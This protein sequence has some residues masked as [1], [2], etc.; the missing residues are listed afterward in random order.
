MSTRSCRHAASN[1]GRFGPRG[2]GDDR[3]RTLARRL[4]I[5]L[6]GTAAAALSMGQPTR[7]ASINDA[8]A[9]AAGGIANYWDSTN[10]YSNVVS[11]DLGSCSGTLI[12]SRTIIT[13]A[14]CF[15][16]NNGTYSG[17]AEQVSFNPNTNDNSGKPKSDV[18][19]AIVNQNF[20]PNANLSVANDIALLSLATPFP[21]VTAAKLLTANPGDAGFPQKD[22]VAVL[23]GYGDTGTG[24]KPDTPADGKRRVAYTQLGGYV[25]ERT[26]TVNGLQTNI[27]NACTDDIDKCILRQGTQPFFA[28]QFRDPAHPATFNYFSQG[29]DPPSLQ[30]G[31]RKGD[32]GGPLFWCPNGTPD[33]C[34][35]DQLV[36]I[37][38]LFG[39]Q[40]PVGG[41][42]EAYGDISGWT[43]VNLFAAWI[44]QNNPL[45]QVAAKPG[46]FNWSN[47]AAWN[48][49]VLGTTTNFPNNAVSYNQPAGSDFTTNFARYYQVTLA[50]AGTVMLDTNPTI[51]TLAIAGGQSRL[52]IGAPF[53]LTTALAT[54]LSAGSLTMNGGTLV[55]PE[56][57]IS[58]GLLSG[59][60]TVTAAGGTSGLCNSGVCD[61]GG[62]VQPV[63]TLTIQGNYTQTNGTL[64]FQVT[65]T[66]TT[67]R[68]A[69]NPGTATLGGTVNAVVAPGLY[70]SSTL[71]SNTLTATAVTGSFAHATSSSTFFA[72]VPSYTATSV[73]LTLNRIPF[74]DV[75]GMNADMQAVGDALESV[76]SP[77]TT[78]PAA[79][80]FDDVLASPTTQVLEELSGE[81]GAGGGQIATFQIMNQ[82]L[83]QMLNPFGEDRA[84]FGEAVSGP[85]GIGPAG[86]IS[87]FAPERKI[88]PPPEAA[89]AYA[90]VR[91][92]EGASAP[93]WS[94]WASA[95]GGTNDTRGDPDGAGTHDFTAHTAGV[96]VGL[97][98]KVRPDTLLGFA[99]AGGSTSW[100]VA[101][102]LGGGRSD[103]FQ[104]GLYGSRRFGPAYL[105]AALAYA[106][107]WTS[108]SRTIMLAG[109]DTLTANFYAQSWGARAEAGYALTT[110]PVKFTPYVAVQAQSYHSPAYGETST[111]G[112]GLFAL[113]YAAHTGSAVRT[114]LGT[115]LGTDFLMGN[116]A[117][118]AV[119]GRAA[120]AHDWQDD[121]QATAAFQILPGENF[122]VNGAKP[123]ADVALLTAGA[124]I[125]MAKGLSLMAKLDGEF[126]RGTQTYAGTARVRY[127][128]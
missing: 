96:A 86:G 111:T 25:V 16:N 51:D 125:R 92:A 21:N 116:G 124:E 58:G 18:S 55:S 19:T 89:R 44:G 10:V 26:M 29:S 45:R 88:E 113:D 68:L 94:V 103:V 49:S 1:A 57:R 11:I 91:P 93:R 108:T 24:S 47:P 50:N 76:Y 118:A 80:F 38:E 98:Y 112:F 6:G 12:N 14:H 128:W 127:T 28:S 30:G 101:Q 7:A 81:A 17:G 105:S 126:G 39:G 75:S 121:P 63:G 53:T 15:I 43:P 34:R 2:P 69:V 13:A 84:G 102:G 48:D 20:K 82:F 104:A 77:T 122:I 71:Y 70:G 120:W 9:A 62:I 32:S 110:A 106:G 119:F 33:K 97:D 79:D 90:A 61:T 40:A 73:D 54:T 99:L 35:L 72:V 78:G 115:R 67:D 36:L 107:H 4:A 3:R 83:M 41:T 60:G 117:K 22:A 52:S 64:R 8:T 42:D 123:A 31:T 100:G 46:D 95:F 65:P 85:A 56:F 37:G 5:L 23:V 74:G 66:G 109:T 27:P 59:T 114:E 87:R